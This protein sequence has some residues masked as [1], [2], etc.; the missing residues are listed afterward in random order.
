MN[1]NILEAKQ[2]CFAIIERFP[3]EQLLNLEASLQAMYNM[4]DEAIDDAYCLE[5]YRSS[6]D[7]DNDEPMDFEQFTRELGLEI[8]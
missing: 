1:T 5:L 2:R 8:K 4:I 7:E 6:F 3:A